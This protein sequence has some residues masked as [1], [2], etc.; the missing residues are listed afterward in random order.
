MHILFGVLGLSL[1]VSAAPIVLCHTQLKPRIQNYFKTKSPE[2]A[3]ATCSSKILQAPSLC[4]AKCIKCKCNVDKS[5]ERFKWFTRRGIYII[6]IWVYVA[7]D[8][9]VIQMH[10]VEEKATICLV[11]LVALGVSCLCRIQCSVPH[12]NEIA[13]K[14][15]TFKSIHMA[16]RQ[17]TYNMRVFNQY[18]GK[19]T[20]H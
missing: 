14:H 19:V 6:Q 9:A 5:P 3:F 13:A 20:T 12:A 15:N 18:N 1:D 16:G 2:Q 10:V 7:E 4:Y 8:D 11:Q 17:L